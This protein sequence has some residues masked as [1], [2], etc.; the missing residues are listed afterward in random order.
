MNKF[1]FTFNNKNYTRVSKRKA[2]TLFKQGITIFVSPSRLRPFGY[3]G[4]THEINYNALRERYFEDNP[5][6]IFLK[7]CNE[8]IYYNCNAEC[9][10]YMN[11]FIEIV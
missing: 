8:F 5:D 1:T 7:F 9:G 11:F 4:G 10:K 2:Q 3:W 6:C